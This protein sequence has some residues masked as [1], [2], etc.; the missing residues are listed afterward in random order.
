MHTVEQNLIAG[1]QLHRDGKIRQAMQHY[2]RALSEQPDQ[3]DAL[4][5]LGV[6]LGQT[7]Q[8]QQAIA[9]IRRAISTRPTAA[10]YNSLGALYQQTGKWNRAM[11]CFLAALRIEPRYADA[12]N[13]LSNLWRCRG[14]FRRAAAAA[15]HATRIAPQHAE[16]WNTL[17][18]AY[19]Q[20][21]RV[22]Q[23]EQCLHRALAQ[24][25]SL[26]SARINLGNLY[27]DAGR[28]DEAVQQYRLAL[29]ANP[30]DARAHCNLGCML[31]DQGRLDQAI[32]ALET[33]IAL[34][35]NWPEAHLS[36]ASALL[37]CGRWSDGWREFRWRLLDGGGNLDGPVPPQMP[38][39]VSPAAG[40]PATGTLHIDH[41]PTLGIGTTI[42]FAALLRE[43]PAR[44]AR[45]VVQTD[46]RLVPIFRRSFPR[47]RFVALCP[48]QPSETAGPTRLPGA[49]TA[50]EAAEA[51]APNGTA[52]DE[53]TAA[54]TVRLSLG[55]LPAILR[56]S[57]ASFPPPTP[58]LQADPQQRALWRGRLAELGIGAARPKI[59]ITWRGGGAAVERMRRNIEPTDLR[60]LAALAQ[61]AAWID[62]QYDSTP[63]DRQ[64]LAT[65]AAL[66]LHRLP[67]LD[68]FGQLD[69]LAAL[70]CELDLVIGVDNST[71]H[72]AGALGVETW[73][74][75]PYAANW[76]WQR[77]RSDTLWFPNMRLF[78]QPVPGDWRS[79][80]QHVAI[81]LAHRLGASRPALP[82]GHHSTSRNV[83]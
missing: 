59:G 11:R 67:D 37:T 28:F 55:D 71:I 68:C 49:T 75:L 44:P 48:S 20:L 7:G 39:S 24:K 2:H 36:L 45:V 9:R 64:R 14:H 29:E 53:T 13:N 6:A 19:K 8:T 60:P 27:R 74:L 40:L 61:D 54:P 3:P 46:S 5:L 83:A 62:L 23:A 12:L 58:Y 77:G 65:D 80:C 42:L 4:H 51:T 82:A 17:A 52:D 16:A 76:R 21:G 43:L 31:R 22:D 81:E 15:R 50:D 33:A 72:L 78:R 41:D 30:N 18:I 57:A 79:V 1:L 32:A 34:Q 56:G 73:T 35:P 66:A 70:M 26:T 25:P 38:D 69:A 63:H 10:F 47:V